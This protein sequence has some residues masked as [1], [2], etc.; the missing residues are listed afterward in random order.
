MI[1]FNQEQKKVHHL[2]YY[3]SFEKDLGL[4]YGKMGIS[5]FFFEY[6]RY[7]KCSVYTDFGADLLDKIWSQ[8]HLDIPIHFASGLSGIGW[9]VEYLIQNEYIKGDSNV[10]CE[11]IDN[12][13]MQIDLMRLRDTSLYTGLNGIL[14]YISARLQGAV[15]QKGILPF[16]TYYINNL[17]RVKPS[18]FERNFEKL[19]SQ[20]PFCLKHFIKSNCDSDD[21]SFSIP[22]GLRDGIAGELL[23]KM[24]NR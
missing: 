7:T 12:K 24:W 23:L 14:Y 2:M 5:I 16:D 10:I 22:L 21:S 8:V 17:F 19:F 13:I 3:S 6:G 4:F 1:H 11:D 9:G 20:Y 18:L 15:S